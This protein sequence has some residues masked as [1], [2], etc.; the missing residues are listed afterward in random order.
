[1]E[2]EKKLQDELSAV[3]EEV[4]QEI[5]ETVE[6]IV[7]ADNTVQAVEEITENVAEEV[8]ETVAEEVAETVA[9]EVAEEIKPFKVFETEE[10][11]NKV[12]QSASSKAKGEI[13]KELGIN[14]VAEFKEQYEKVE[15]LTEISNTLAEV[16]SKVDSLVEEKL[17]L[18]SIILATKYPLSEEASKMFAELVSVKRGDRDLIEVA[19]EVYNTL[20][21][22]FK[23]LPT[24]VVFGADR[25]E[26]Q[27]LTDDPFIQGFK[28]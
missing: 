13:L 7:D 16:Q 12:L 27:N 26:A 10:D 23:Q 17:R 5:A 3:V 14:S 24:K 22:G 21:S 20:Q 11:F 6:E 9:E 28:K 18:E 15:Q 1:M 4:N 25:S 19:D 2:N 8:A